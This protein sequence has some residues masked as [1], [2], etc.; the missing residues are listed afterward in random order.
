MTEEPNYQSSEET[1]KEVLEF[2]L[3]CSFSKALPVN[4]NISQV[5]NRLVGEEFVNKS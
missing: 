4:K 1:I 3:K 2:L 5:D